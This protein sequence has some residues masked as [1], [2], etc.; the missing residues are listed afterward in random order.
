[1][2]DE[3][4]LCGIDMYGSDYIATVVE[5]SHETL[6]KTIGGIKDNYFDNFFGFKR[7]KID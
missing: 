2:E 6:E 5:A 1:M 4:F 3:F 7:I